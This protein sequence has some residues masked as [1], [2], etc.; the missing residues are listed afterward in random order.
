MFYYNIYKTDFE[1]TVPRVSVQLQ[2]SCCWVAASSSSSSSWRQQ[3]RQR[4]WA[5]SMAWAGHMV[6]L[7]ELGPRH[8]R[9]ELSQSS[10]TWLEPWQVTGEITEKSVPPNT[11]YV[12]LW[13]VDTATYLRNQ[14]WM[15]H[16]LSAQII[17]M[18]TRL[19]WV[20][21]QHA[22]GGLFWNYGSVITFILLFEISPGI[23]INQFEL[24]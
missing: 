13:H 17:S 18:R 5:S 9:Q 23:L 22:P 3:S 6:Q 10:Q 4:P 16:H 12:E 20:A 24:H 11:V 21:S 2:H 19:Q 14:I 1:L 8:S 15:M 7:A